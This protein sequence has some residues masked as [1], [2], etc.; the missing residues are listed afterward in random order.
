MDKPARLRALARIPRGG[1]P[2]SL[3]VAFIFGIAVYRALLSIGECSAQE[4]LGRTS[5]VSAHARRATGSSARLWLCTNSLP[6]RTP[7]CAAVR[8]PAFSSKQLVQ[9][10]V[11][12]S[13]RRTDAACVHC[14]CVPY[15]W[16]QH[17][18]AR[19]RRPLITDSYA[20]TPADSQ[21]QQ[22]VRAAGHSRLRPNTA[23]RRARQPGCSAP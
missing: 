15:R 17:L 21:P 7:G 1:Q 18:T 4:Q 6:R 14:C 10:R 9:H 3:I 13:A 19:L 2:L 16:L 20:D 5:R 11:R 8:A 23:A 12:F 22:K